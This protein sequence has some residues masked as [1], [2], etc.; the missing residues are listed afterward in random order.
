[1]ECS[2][3]GFVG[4]ILVA[5]IAACSSPATL[6]GLSTGGTTIVGGT[7]GHTVLT[8]SNGGTSTAQHGSGGAAGAGSG[9]TVG[10]GGVVPRASGGVAHGSGGA[11]GI[12]GTV[13]RASGGASPS[14]GSG[15]VAGPGADA[16]PVTV[17]PPCL[18]DP[19][20][21]LMAGDSY[22]AAPSYVGKAIV[23]AAAADGTLS[24]S[25]SYQNLAVPGTTVNSGQIPGQLDTALANY[26]KLKTMI[27]DG[28]GND[29]IQS[30][31]CLAAGSDRVSYCTDI[32]DQC[33]KNFKAMGEKAQAAGV[34]D[35]ILFQYP[36][37][38]PIGGADILRYGVE[39][40]KKAAAELTTAEYRVYLVDT[41][42]LMKDHPSWYVDGLIH[43]NADGAKLIGDAIYGLMKSNCIAQPESR[44]CC[45]SW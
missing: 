36:D 37:N 5:T 31:V 14:A 11:V 26:P 22:V 15:G 8:V 39:Q 19:Q 16:A 32:V 2:K 25:Q 6:E 24:A 18:K 4:S 33:V 42:P 12:G 35:V 38:V 30:I 41:A 23:A 28:C 20:Q 34:T 27:A 21:V 17:R 43:V 40:A 13:S 1:M 9:G 7:G 10:V 44:G 3:T 45:Q 29:I